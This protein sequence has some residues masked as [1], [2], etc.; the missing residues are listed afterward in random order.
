MHGERA[1]KGFGVRVLRTNQ[2]KTL[3]S[4]LRDFIG[5]YKWG[6]LAP[7]FVLSKGGQI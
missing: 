2:G 6:G 5:E 7:P 3:K 4:F 1:G